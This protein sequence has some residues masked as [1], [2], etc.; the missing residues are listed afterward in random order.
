MQ[1]ITNLNTSQNLVLKLEGYSSTALTQKVNVYFTSQFTGEVYEN[2]EVTLTETNARYQTIPFTPPAETSP[3]TNSQMVEGLYLVKVSQF[4][5]TTIYA[6]RL[7]FVRS[8]P[9][10][11]E[12][13]YDDYTV[14]D[15]TAYNVYV[16]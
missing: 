14:G 3:P 6:Q 9:A 8:D 10:F 11:I 12:S 16:K 5:G 2:L 1:Q 4:G 7:A 15:T 13:E